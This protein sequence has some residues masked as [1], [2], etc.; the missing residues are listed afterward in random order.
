MNDN[1]ALF[2]FDFDGTLVK[3]HSHN[4]IGKWL[5]GLIAANIQN[6]FFSSYDE[7]DKEKARLE[8]KFSIE[9][10]EVFLDSNKLGWKNEEQLICLFK[11]II[12]SGHK[13]AIASFNDYHHAVKYA[14]EQLLDKE[15]VKKIYIKSGLPSNNFQEIQNCT[16]KEYIREI[17]NNTGVTNKKNVFFMDDDIKHVNA[18]KDYGIT[19]VLVE[20][21]GKEHIHQACN[22][23]Y[24][25]NEQHEI[26]V[27][28]K[29]TDTEFFLSEKDLRETIPFDPCSDD[30][31]LNS[32][33]YT[34]W[35]E[36]NVPT[37]GNSSSF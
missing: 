28:F 1:T 27:D 10:M 2:I 22:F 24:K 9:L 8:Q 26:Y 35:G 36:G 18:A 33:E 12:S 25:F 14:L 16:K 37:L 15:I 13:I 19:A 3:G 30:Y 6:R 20:N 17:I 7:R 5:G 23:L 31:Y 21:K 4:Y 29:D 32:E 34:P 11:N